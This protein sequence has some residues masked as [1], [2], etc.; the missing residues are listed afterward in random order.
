MAATSGLASAEK[1]EVPMKTRLLGDS[2]T[3]GSRKISTRVTSIL[4]S[5]Q[6]V[7]GIA[8]TT[9]VV[10]LI[11]VSKLPNGSAGVTLATFTV[12]VCGELIAPGAVTVTK[13][14]DPALA[15]IWNVPVPTPDGGLAVI[16]E[17]S[18]VAVQ[19]TFAPPVMV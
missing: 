9:P 15:E 1:T 11:G 19:A 8:P 5:A 7:T 14:L 13:P 10:P 4:S 16:L 12:M 3:I 2:V 18:D 6:P 17:W